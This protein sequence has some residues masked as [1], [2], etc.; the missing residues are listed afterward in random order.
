MFT[1]AIDLLLIDNLEL[2]VDESE[3]PL[4]FWQEGAEPQNLRFM[5]SQEKAPKSSRS[6][7][8]PIFQSTL[9]PR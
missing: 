2:L 4:D 8:R 3:A 7:M 6:G 1:H 9:P 5:N